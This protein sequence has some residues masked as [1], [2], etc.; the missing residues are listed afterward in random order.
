MV[1][2]GLMMGVLGSS[3]CYIITFMFLIETMDKKTSERYSVVIQ[4]FHG[5]G[6]VVA[7]LSFWIIKDWWL[8]FFFCYL[9]PS[10][11]LLIYM[12][13]IIVDTPMSLILRNEPIKALEELSTIS[14]MNHTDDNLTLEDIIEAK[15]RYL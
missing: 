4:N 15:E 12:Y 11:T 7:I 3:N 9:V 13:S 5:F 8:I 6:A 10:V 2:L 14:K 1:T